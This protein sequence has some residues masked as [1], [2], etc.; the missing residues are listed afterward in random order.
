MY[1]YVY[2]ASTL[3]QVAMHP[4]TVQI[5]DSLVQTLNPRP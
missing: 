1:I 3:A 5:A 4:L 2:N